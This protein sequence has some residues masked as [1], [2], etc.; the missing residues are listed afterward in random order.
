M[1]CQV[2]Y[3][4]DDENYY[5]GSQKKKGSHSVTTWRCHRVHPAFCS[6]V[7]QIIL[8][9]SFLNALHRKEHIEEEEEVAEI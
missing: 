6:E 8:L 3:T 7:L 4:R 2:R 5:H 9:L 1:N